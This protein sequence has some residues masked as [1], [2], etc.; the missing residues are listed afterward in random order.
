MTTP[1][2]LPQSTKDYLVNVLRALSGGECQAIANLKLVKWIDRGQT[3]R[4]HLIGLVE[5]NNTEQELGRKRPWT[6][7]FG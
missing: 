6:R 3:M 7:A 5:A 1:I 2:E 4:M